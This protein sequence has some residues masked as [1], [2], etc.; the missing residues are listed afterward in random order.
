MNELLSSGIELMLVG[1]GIVFT[2]LGMLVL[3]INGMSTLIQ[4]FFPENPVVI[5][6]G[7]DPRMIAAISAA[8]HQY[9]KKYAKH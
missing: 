1:M 3:F 4:R 7:D 6:Q 8:V 2:F 9:R 5:Q